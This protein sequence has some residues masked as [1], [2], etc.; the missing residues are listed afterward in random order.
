M[1]DN[2]IEIRDLCVAAKQPDEA[3][4]LIK[5]R[6]SMADARKRLTDILAERDEKTHTDGHAPSSNSK[7][8]KTAQPA[9]LKTADVWAARRNLH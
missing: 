2:L 3:A 9:A 7:P 1:S 4:K 8:A 5:A 6:A